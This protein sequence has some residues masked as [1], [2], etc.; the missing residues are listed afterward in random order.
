MILEKIFDQTYEESKLFK[1]T[2]KKEWQIS[3]ARRKLNQVA[4]AK[5]FSINQTA[6]L[7]T[8]ISELA[9][10]LFFHTTDGGVITIAI[11]DDVANTAIKLISR[12]TGPGIVSIERALQDGYSTNGGLGGGLPGVKR[13]M[14]EFSISSTQNGTVISC[15]KWRS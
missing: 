9:Y 4:K 3:T 6:E 2:I 14:D 1:I 12:D 13:L 8:S 10:N 11:I 5:G 15:M 7:V